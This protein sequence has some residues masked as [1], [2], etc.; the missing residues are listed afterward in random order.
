MTFMFPLGDGCHDRYGKIR[1]EYYQKIGWCQKHS[2]IKRNCRKTCFCMGDLSPYAHHKEKYPDCQTTRWGCCQDKKTTKQDEIG[3][4]CPGKFI[5][6][7]W[8]RIDF[9]M[10]QIV[11]VM[12]TQF[13]GGFS[14][15][16]PHV[17]CRRSVTSNFQIFSDLKCAYTTRPN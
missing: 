3:S 1:C 13:N 12:H 9:H 8:R 6:W 17:P 5:V 7:P 14:G 10:A 16:L 15:F 11:Q 2:A 4:N